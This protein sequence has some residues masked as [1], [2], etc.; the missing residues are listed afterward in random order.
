MR[1]A[2][3][4]ITPYAMLSRAF[5]GIKGK[6]FIVNLPGSPKAALENLNVLKPVFEHAVQLL[7]EDPNAEQ[8][9]NPLSKKG[10]P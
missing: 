3:L 5:S 10:N 7:R 9:H 4:A 6:T 2:S 1:S 8:G